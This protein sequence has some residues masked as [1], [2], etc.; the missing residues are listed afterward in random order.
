[1]KT[2][3]I[4]DREIGNGKSFIIA[5]LSANHGKNLD[6][7]LKTVEAA[8]WAGADAIKLQTVEPSLITLD[9]DNAYFKV[10][11]DTPWGGQTL[12]ELEVATFLPR[13]W[14]QPLF[15]KAAQL[16]LHCFSSPFDLTAID[17]LES[18]NCPAYKIASFEITDVALIHKAAST[19]KPVIISTGIATQDDIA[20]AVATCRATGNDNIALLKCTS[21][22][23]TPLNNVDLRSM[24]NLGRD[25]ECIFGLSDHT[26]GDIVATGAAA[27]GAAII[28]KHFILDA[29]VISA[30]SGFSML[31]TDFK[32]MVTRI[33]DLEAALGQSN[34]RV[35]ESMQSGRRFSRSLFVVEDVRAGDVFTDQNVRS[36]RPGNGL[37]PKYLPDILGKRATRDIA[38]GTPFCQSMLTP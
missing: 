24:P 34:W 13:E 21:A 2:F 29:S 5:E 25:Y 8:A 16:G 35:N 6:I 17:F 9:C 37:A 36:I 27:L 22:Y 4:A 15:E 1:M 14:H 18:L 33:R 32:T 30:D 20:L 12:Y 11:N 38:R 28:E 7:A 3:S 31:P 23:P 19:H 10:P 26:L